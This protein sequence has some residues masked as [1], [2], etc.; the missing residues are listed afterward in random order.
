MQKFL[1]LLLVHVLAIQAFSQTPTISGTIRDTGEN[2]ALSNAVISVIRQS[3][4]VLLGFTR[5]GPDGR[6]TLRNMP[7]T[8]IQLLVTYPNYAD[9]T[10]IVKGK[11]GSYKPGLIAMIRKSELLEQVIVKGKVS[12]IRIKGDTTEFVADSFAVRAG[13]N[14]EELLKKLPGIQVNSKGEITAQGERVTKVLVDGE[15]FFSDDPA[16]VTQ[17]LPADAVKEVQLYDKKS[18]QAEFTGIDDGERSRTINLKLKE[19][20]KKGYFGKIKL[21]GG[22][23]QRFDNDL[24]L[25]VFKGNRKFSA[26]GIMSNTGRGNLDWDER[27]KYGGGDNFEYDE[28]NGYFYSSNPD[29]EFDWSV[30]SD[31]GLPTTWTGGLHYSDKWDEDRKKINGNYRYFKR[32]L[33]NESSTKSQFILPDTQ[34]FSSSNTKEMSTRIRNSLQGFYEFKMDSL[35]TLKV[36]VFGAATDASGSS[37]VTGQSLNADSG[38]VN[39]NDRLLASNTRNNDF[40]ADVLWRKKF[41]LKGRT[42]SLSVNTVSGEQVLDG[43]LNSDISYYNASGNADSSERID[44]KKDNSTNR[45]SFST[46][47]VYTE[48]I[49]KKTFLSINYGY[50]LSTEKA[51]RN[52]F[53]KTN[54]TGEYDKLNNLLSNDFRFRSDAH[55]GGADV[56]INTKRVVYQAGSSLSYAQYNQKDLVLD[57]A[58]SYSFL[59]LFPQASI[60]YTIRPQRRLNIRYRGRSEAPTIDQVQPIFQNSNPLV[61]Q[62]GNPALRQQFNHN[63]NIN[64]NDYKVLNQRG[65]WT[66]ISMNSTDNAIGFS[67]TVDRGGKT[68]NQFIN[69]DGNRNMSIYMGYYR[70]LKKLKMYFNVSPTISLSRLSNQINGLMNVNNNQNY[71]MDLRL[72]YYVDKKFNFA[73]SPNISYVSSKS[74]LRPDV[75]TQYFTT[76]SKA[77][78]W[79]ML[80][81]KFEISSDVTFNIRQRTNVFAANRNAIKWDASLAKKFLK[82]DKAELRVHVF[83][84]LDQNIGFDRNA[85]T[86]IITEN[87]YTTFRRYGMISFTL[88]IAKNPGQ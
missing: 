21:A 54:L 55:S 4:S 58:R 51:L 74:S 78:G 77:E 71:Q 69:V 9:F 67:T 6:F 33:A 62:V 61:I 80:P 18:E 40:N 26:Y 83:D 59:N 10:D 12:A 52:T 20:R 38:L 16:V 27:R 87:S 24:M 85:Q 46:R 15:E 73:L 3:D 41:G 8:G 44:Q 48:P 5:S 57:T 14:V 68:I 36:N 19:D 79:V 66:G 28:D 65:I 53:D 82:N 64:F 11:D 81:A 49:F 7:D 60:I 86:N 63:L 35:S 25:N 70:Q 88:N 37:R 39:T 30:R 45:L 47:A 75:K 17:N 72:G 76:S 13:A 23:E 1:I 42:L 56:K 34:Y 32:N 29:G 31:E 2:K 84:I 43:F 22:N 50:R